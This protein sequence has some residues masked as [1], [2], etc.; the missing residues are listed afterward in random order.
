MATLVMKARNVRECLTQ[1]ILLG[2]LLGPIAGLVIWWLPLGLDPRAQATVAIVAF[3]LVYWLMEPIEH[4]VTALIGCYLFWALQIVP[5]SVAFSGFVNTSPWFVFGALLMGEAV[6]R[7]GLGKRIGYTILCKVGTSYTR[8]LFGSITLVYLLSFL[9]PTPNAELTILISLLLGIVAVFGLTPH[10][11]VAKGLFLGVT[12]SCTLFAKMNLAAAANLLARG[13]IEEQTGIQVWWGQWFLA[14]FPAALVTVVAC[15]LTIRWLYPAVAY[16]FAGSQQSLQDALHTMGPWSRDEQKTLGWLLLAITLWATDF[17]HH[18]NPAVIA[19]GIDLLLTLPKVGL[20]DAKAIKSVNFLLIIFI[21]GALSMGNVLTQTQV[22]NIL[23]EHLI[24]GL[25]PL[26]SDGLRA[27]IAL[28]WGGFVYHFLLAEDKVMVTTMLP[29]LLKFTQL[30]GY[31]PVAIGMIWAFAAGGK[32]FVYQS[33][34]LIYGYSYGYFTGRDLLKV[35]GILTL[36]EGIVLMVLVPLYWPLIGLP[37]R[38][39]SPVLSLMRNA[40]TLPAVA[41]HSPWA[42]GASLDM[43]CLQCEP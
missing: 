19:L 1:Q 34:V 24:Q 28:Y 12:Y 13:L 29:V 11:T 41:L 10:S 43:S 39:A 27:A 18:I 17:L 14:F 6:S 38:N 7:T 32:L 35:A 8:L 40:N 21:S 26:L 4:G 22:L 31:N 30:T 5:F 2:A 20:L 3:L 25:T 42:T 33:S 37:W 36:V 16:E 15:W 9:V 23:T